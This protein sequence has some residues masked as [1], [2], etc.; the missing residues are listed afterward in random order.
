M[1][2]RTPLHEQPSSQP[3]QTAIAF[4]TKDRMV[5]PKM[6]SEVIALLGRLLL[7]AARRGNQSEVGD[8]A[9]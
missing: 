4:P 6:R 2:K 8:D 3:Q 1:R 5:N 9:P 7:E